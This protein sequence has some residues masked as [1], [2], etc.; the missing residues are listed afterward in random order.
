MRRAALAAVCLAL[1]GGAVPVTPAHAGLLSRAQAAAQVKA[2]AERARAETAARAAAA[3]AQ[4]EAVAREAAARAQAAADRLR[5]AREQVLA[6]IDAGERCDLPGSEQRFLRW[7]DDNWYVPA[8]NG[9]F[10]A[11]QPGE[12]AVGWN[13]FGRADVVEGNDPFHVLGGSQ[14]LEMRAGSVVTSPTFCVDKTMPHFRYMMSPVHHGSSMLTIIE[15][16]DWSTGGLW[17]PAISL[18]NSTLLPNQWWP[19]EF[20]SLSVKI[21]SVAYFGKVAHVRIKFVTLTGRYRVDNVLLDPYR[22]R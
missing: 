15:F 10:E 4:A 20:S 17:R 16:R 22:R 9:G 7:S 19:S 18:M 12:A 2:A 6:L 21:P 1:V 5:A 14:S 8:P 11:T 3:R 13:I